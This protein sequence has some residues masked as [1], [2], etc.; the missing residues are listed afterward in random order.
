MSIFARLAASERSGQGRLQAGPPGDLTYWRSG[1]ARVLKLQLVVEPIVAVRV[2]LPLPNP[3][4]R[5]LLRLGA[6]LCL[7]FLQQGTRPLGQRD[8]ILAVPQRSLCV[9]ILGAPDG[10]SK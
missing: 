10:R 8:K 1:P 9:S 5:D 4:M 2:F 7:P 6:L 3:F